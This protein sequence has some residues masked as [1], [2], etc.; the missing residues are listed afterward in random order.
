MTFLGIQRVTL[1]LIAALFVIHAPARA[2]EAD[3]GVLANLI[4]QALSSPTTSVSIGAVD[5]VL[6]SDATISNIVLSD[7]DG[8]WM[9]IDKARLVWRRLALLSRRLEVDQLTIGHMQFLRRPLPS[10]APPP[11]DAGGIRSILPELPVRVVIKQFAIEELSLGEPLIGVAARL[12]IA[13][14]ATLGPPSEGLDLT[15]TARRLY[16][17]GE[18][19]ALMTY[20]PA[21]DKLTLS[22]NSEEP[23]G[24][25]FVHLVNLPGLPPARLAFNGAGALDNFTAKLDFSAG[26][27]VWA[28]GEVVVARKDAGRRL[29][30]DLNSR[31][32]GMTPPIIRPIFAG[33]TT[34]KGDLLF[35]DDS[36]IVTP[37][38]HLVSGNARLDIEGGKSVNDTLDIKIHAGATPG[39]TQIGKL[40]LNASIVGP[41]ASP[42]IEGAFDVADIHVAEGSLEH[43]AATFHAAPNGSLADEATRIAFQGQ[44]VMS[45]LA[46]ADPA[47]AQAVGSEAKLTLS[48]SASPGGD[49]AFDALELAASDLDARYSG[50]LAPKVVRGRLEVAA[51]DLSR[52]ALLAGT[53]LK[54]EARLTAELDGAPRY[55]E[56][57]ATVDARATKL[58][59]GYPLLDKITGGDL[60]V[61]GAA[62][63]MTGGGFGFTDLVAEGARGSARLNGSY[64]T[65]K[66]DLDARID[67]PEVQ[68]VDPRV[69]GRAA[70][71]AALTGTPDDLG[72][73][74][75][76]TLS[77]GRLLDR[78]T[79][80]LTLEAEASHLTKLLEAK[81]SL[82]GDV[83]GHQL[84]GS[85]H[86]AARAD[87]GWA[88]DSLVL[89]LA[90]ARLDGA[91]TIGADRLTDGKLNFSATNLDDLSPLVLTKLSGA[92]Q[93]KVEAASAS[94]KQAL[95]VAATSDGM[96]LGGARIEG[97]KVDMAVDDLWAARGVSGQARLARAEFGGQSL[98]DVRL[99]ATARGEFER[100]RLH[101]LGARARSQ[102]ARATVRRAANPPRPR[103][104]YGGR[105]RA[106]PRARGSGDA[107]L[108]RRRARHP[109]LR[110][111]RRLRPPV[112]LRPR[113]LDAR[114]SRDGRRLAARGARH[115]FARPWPRWRRR[116]RR[117]HRRNAGQSH[118]R[119]ASAPE[120]GQRYADAKRRRAAAR[121]GR[122]RPSRRRPHFP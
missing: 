105:R 69:V 75:K 63:T 114:P 122:L 108:W 90:S 78:K 82:S 56:L 68:A 29:T 62:R 50:L 9:K 60:K 66:V 13:G 57:N 47:L 61:T 39:A 20:V 103:E 59:T 5:G 109:E 117:D 116:R 22:I 37:G 35:N 64:A 34:L 84:Q 73:N 54:G 33:E 104:P 120:A 74:L 49:I 93:A 51:R 55:G 31:L 76:A 27:D 58:V 95:S 36:T 4:S 24:G 48:G 7:R 17:A 119:L 12:N 32:E 38:L 53:A 25:L 41:I 92:V 97:L 28:N 19:R 91:V 8:P 115:F 67:V 65:D 99:T 43:A 118:R 96:S 11:P 87:G 88:I 101:G 6:S 44:A 15:L 89:S 42:T 40:D 3:K 94:G 102:S 121:C 106:A 70:V 23:A 85:A 83:D 77:E 21:T 45:G 113:G 100:S 80:G 46:L 107:D 30:L 112:R 18:F 10:Q 81:A 14:K 2:D 52:F 79:S 98:A 86:V 71:V 111:S 1:A 16:A 26:P 110:A 72:A